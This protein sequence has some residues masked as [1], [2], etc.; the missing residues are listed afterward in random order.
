MGIKRN[1]VT[2]IVQKRDRSDSRNY[3]GYSNK[4]N[5]INKVLE[6]ETEN[7]EFLKYIPVA[8]IATLETFTRMLIKEIVDNGEPF[9]SNAI[10][11]MR[12]QF[13]FDIEYLID[14]NGKR[15]S[16]GEIFSHQVR[17]NKF[18]DLASIFE[19]L[20]GVKLIEGLTKTNYDELALS[21]KD[22]SHFKKNY[23]NYISSIESLFKARHIISHEFANDVKIKKQDLSLWLNNLKI[24]M[25]ATSFFVE[26]KLGKYIPYNQM[27]MNRYASK[28]YKK[29]KRELD[30]LVKSIV[31]KNSRGSHKGFIESDVFKNSIENWEIYIEEY[32]K[33]LSNQMI[34]GS[35]YGFIHL[36][37]KERLIRQMI[38]NLKDSFEIYLK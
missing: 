9:L 25:D 30:L 17:L 38:D 29:S 4:L 27:G 2:E 6:I 10:K 31:S 16:I 37:E 1:I 12:E 36:T 13:Y 8:S 7:E 32:A 34:G 5:E 19:K 20:L 3:F 24:F 33:C 22:S 26:K 28:K 11:S 23:N 35:V 15:V 21:K 14:L 18:S